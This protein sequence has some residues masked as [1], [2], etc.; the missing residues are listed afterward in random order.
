MSLLEALELPSVHC[1]RMP[2]RQPCQ[3]TSVTI[4]RRSDG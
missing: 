2:V 1:A 4:Q 3:G